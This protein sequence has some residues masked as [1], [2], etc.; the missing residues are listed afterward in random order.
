[1]KEAIASMIEVMAEFV[2][3]DPNQ[4]GEYIKLSLYNYHPFN[5]PLFHNFVNA[6]KLKY[7][8]NKS[9]SEIIAG[10]FSLVDTGD[11]KEGLQHM[12]QDFLTVMNSMKEQVKGLSEEVTK[13]RADIANG[14]GGGGAGSVVGGGGGGGGS[15][16][17]PMI[18]MAPMAPPSA[19][20]DPKDVNTWPATSSWV[21]SKF[22]FNPNLQTLQDVFNMVQYGYVSKKKK[23]FFFPTSIF[24]I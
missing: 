1:M 5:K 24:F 21:E 2:I 16:V 22:Q 17:A 14:G 13:L 10:A 4:T 12:T 6:L 23:F 7:G 18:P 9:A 20:I 3:R 19:T 11:V 15:G 8:E